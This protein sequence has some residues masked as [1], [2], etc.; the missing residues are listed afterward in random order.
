MPISTPDQIIEDLTTEQANALLQKLTHINNSLFSQ[1][2]GAG[3]FQ[4]GMLCEKLS[5]VAKKPKVP[6]IQKEEV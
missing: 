5:N 6:T 1:N 4:F 2:S 3:F